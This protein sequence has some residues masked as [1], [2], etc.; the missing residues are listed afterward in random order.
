MLISV[1]L[2]DPE[3]PTI[4]TNWPRSIRSERSDK[5]WTLSPVGRR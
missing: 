1:D 2:P 4:A 3:A 5:A